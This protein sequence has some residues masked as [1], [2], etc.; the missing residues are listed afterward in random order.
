VKRVGLS[1]SFIHFLHFSTSE[2]LVHRTAACMNP[3]SQRFNHYPGLS[4]TTN[5]M[6]T[7]I[8]NAYTLLREAGRGTHAKVYTSLPTR[9]INRARK[10]LRM[11]ADK[12]IVTSTLLSRVVAL[13]VSHLHTSS[14]SN[15]IR[16]L[17]AIQ[18]QASLH[19]GGKL[20]VQ[21]LDYA[22]SP[23]LGRSW[24]TMATTPMCC[25]LATLCSGLDGALP[26]PLL[27]LIITQLFDAFWFLHRVCVPP[28][29]HGDVGLSN[30]IISYLPSSSPPATPS[31]LHNSHH[32]NRFRHRIPPPPSSFK[33]FRQGKSH[34]SREPVLRDQRTYPGLW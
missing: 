16:I 10:V 1:C 2:P 29:A 19:K 24:F 3:V 20:C 28:I 9:A 17:L 21:L 15:E 5:A 26:E 31:R 34:R 7:Q 11:G 33:R 14:L 22:L 13:K 32:G 8:T 30:V 27:W 25:D 18:Q 4:S 23:S 12:D 6:S